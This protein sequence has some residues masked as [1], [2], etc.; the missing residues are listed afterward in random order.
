MTYNILLGGHRGAPL[1][2]LVRTVAP[3][4]LLVNESPQ[5]PAAVAPGLRAAGPAVGHAIRDGWP[6]CGLEPD[7]GARPG[8]GPLVKHAAAAPA[9]VR[10]PP[11][12][13]GRPAA[14]TRHAARRGGVPPLPGAGAA[15][16]G[17]WPRCWRTPL[18]SAVRWSSP[19]TSTRRRRDPLGARRSTTASPIH[20]SDAWPTFPSDQPQRRIDA[21]L[22]RGALTVLAHGDPGVPLALQAAASDHRGV[23]AEIEPAPRPAL[24]RRHAVPPARP[25]VSLAVRLGRC[26]S[27]WWSPRP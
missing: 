14:R 11:R 21:L 12:D 24:P 19:V 23:L 4:V 7:P 25:T 2:D 16:R 20:G 17:R 10:A 15:A 27:H 8:R 18:V 6:D 13:R 26:L 5:A 1:H 22:V 3:D 9:A